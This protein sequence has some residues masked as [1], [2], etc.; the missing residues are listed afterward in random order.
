MPAYPDIKVEIALD[1]GLVDIVADRFDA[2]VRLGEHVDKDMIA[3]RIAPICARRSSGSRVFRTSSPAANAAGPPAPPVHQSLAVQVARTLHLGIQEGWSRTKGKVD[4][5]LAFNDL[6]MLRAA[7]LDGL[8]L[9]NLPHDY[10][11]QPLADGLLIRVLDDWCPPYPGYH[12]YYPSRRQPTPAFSLI[13]D[14]LRHR[15]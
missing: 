12:L 5:P 14:A 1:Y 2:G 4:G 8:G 3:V 6:S 11:M 10:V 9:A 13:V 15:V 7:A